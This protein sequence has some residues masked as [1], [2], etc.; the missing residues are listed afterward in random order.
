MTTSSAIKMV[1]FKSIFV[2]DTNYRQNLTRVKELAEDIKERGLL[3]PVIVSNGGEGAQPNVLVGGARRMAAMA[4]LGWENREIPVVVRDY[5]KGDALSRIADN[6]ASNE[7][8][9]STNPYDRAE[10]CHQLLTGTYPV[11]PGETAKP[12]S[13][14]EIEK[15]LGIKDHYLGKLLK[16]FQNIDPDV[17]KSV[18]KQDGGTVHFTQVPIR[19]LI[20][21][22]N[23]DGVGKGDA[24]LEDRA[25]KQAAMLQKWLDEKW[26][27]ESKGKS[28]K[29]PSTKGGGS[30]EGE[31]DGDGDP[32]Q[33]RRAKAIG[34]KKIDKKGHTGEEYLKALQIKIQSATKAD[35]QYIQGQIDATKFFIGEVKTLKGLTASDFAALEP[36]EEVEEETEEEAAE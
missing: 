33:E 8:S 7:Q 26:E 29:G 12:L 25:Q 23:I 6:W 14:K 36:E 22:S 21:I 15:L 3:E 4:L 10:L 27:L 5:K 31:G 11:A 18:R 13:R 20:G 19:V 9:E 17:I 2:P 34:A 35:A 28:R 1:P 16:V 24:K 30:G 32:T